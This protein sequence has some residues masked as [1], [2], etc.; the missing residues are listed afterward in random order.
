M[1]SRGIPFVRHLLEDR[2]LLILITNYLLYVVHV[3]TLCSTHPLASC[4][5]LNKQLPQPTLNTLKSF[6]KIMQ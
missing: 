5:Y 1:Y 6:G 2:N 3:H 4:E